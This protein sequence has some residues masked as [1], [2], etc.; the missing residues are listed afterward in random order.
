MSIFTTAKIKSTLT[1]RKVLVGAGVAALVV[2]T[3]VCV[4][5]G[6]I[7]SLAVAFH[8]LTGKSAAVIAESAEAVAT[9]AE[10]V[11]EAAV[12]SVAD[13]ATKATN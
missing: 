9:I 8:R 13:A 1:N 6:G 2:G 10:S 5:G 3:V 7:S 12:E 4:R 11:S